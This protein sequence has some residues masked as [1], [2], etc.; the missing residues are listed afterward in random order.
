MK[1]YDKAIGIYKT[2]LDIEICNPHYTIKSMVEVYALYNPSKIKDYLH[3]DIQYQK[4]D[5]DNVLLLEAYCLYDKYVEHIY[6]NEIER[7]YSLLKEHTEEKDL[8]EYYKYKADK[9]YSIDKSMT[10]YNK[11]IDIYVD[12]YEHNQAIK[13]IK[14][15]L[16]Y[17]DI[18]LYD[19]VSLYYN[20][21]HIY[22]DIFESEEAWN[23]LSQCID[24]CKQLND[25]LLYQKISSLYAEMYEDIDYDEVPSLRLEAR[26][27]LKMFKPV[28]VGQA[29]RISGVS[30]ADVSVLLVYLEHYNRK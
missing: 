10:L 28:S 7:L 29:S 4:D 2:L 16:S 18:S 30:P 14:E 1:E 3:I 11:I 27:K 17:N 26:Q 24:L 25:S 13:L 5:N 22:Y 6:Q 12:E 21:S 23:V 20:L 19:K 8:I 9:Q 15:L